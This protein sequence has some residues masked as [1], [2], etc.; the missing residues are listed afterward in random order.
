[1]LW[2]Y[3][4]PQP[5]PELPVWE[6]LT[7][8]QSFCEIVISDVPCNWLQYQENLIDP[9]HFEWLHENWPTAIEGQSAPE[10]RW[11]VRFFIS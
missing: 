9:V 7:R 4:G 6:M 8:D 1:M 2:A 11:H 5:A 10:G 3:F